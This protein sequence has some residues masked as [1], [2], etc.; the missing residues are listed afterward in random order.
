MSFPGEF[1]YENIVQTYTRAEEVESLSSPEASSEISMLLATLNFFRS[2]DDHA[3]MAAFFQEFNNVLH[4]MDSESL[5]LVWGKEE[6][7]K[8]LLGFPD[9]K[10]MLSVAHNN[11]NIEDMKEVFSSIVQTKPELLG[12]SMDHDP[13]HVVFRLVEA[14]R[15]SILLVY[16]AEERVSIFD[17]L[18]TMGIKSSRCSILLETV[19]SLISFSD[20]L[21]GIQ[22]Y[23]FKMSSNS[24]RCLPNAKGGA[25][26]L[27]CAGLSY[28]IL[29]LDDMRDFVNSCSKPSDSGS[30]SGNAGTSNE[31]GADNMRVVDR[32]KRKSRSEA[33][34]CDQNR[35]DDEQ[36][37]LYEWG[38]SN[39]FIQPDPVRKRTVCVSFGKADHGKLGHGDTSVSIILFNICDV[40]ANIL[41]V[42]YLTPLYHGFCFVFLYFLCRFI[43]MCPL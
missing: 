7:R 24:F 25:I 42:I 43:A 10:S 15:Q 19:W 41:Q 3:L 8:K 40:A 23:E 17:A 11:A 1:L 4:R 6:F 32:I 39:L 35:S 16:S 30:G 29:M 26:R 18:M 31:G 20:S 27:G 28:P 2:T 13:L 14:C 38:E 9:L 21:F 22:S 36:T 33:V 34:L 5:S 12:S 37:S